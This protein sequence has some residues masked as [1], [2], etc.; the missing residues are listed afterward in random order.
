MLAVWKGVEGV[1]SAVCLLPHLVTAPVLQTLTDQLLN[2]RH[3]LCCG[4]KDE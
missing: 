1:S 3:E 2:A 4:F